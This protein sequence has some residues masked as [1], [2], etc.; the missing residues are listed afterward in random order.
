MYERLAAQIIDSV[1]LPLSLT[2]PRK[3]GR[4]RTERGK[5]RLEDI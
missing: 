5:G 3:R 1:T 2:L 4:G